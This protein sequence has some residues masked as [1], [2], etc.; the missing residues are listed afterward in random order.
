MPTGRF[1]E[2]QNLVP[3]GDLYEHAA[4]AVMRDSVAGVPGLTGLLAGRVRKEPIPIFDINGTL[5]F[6]DYA[7]GRGAQ[8]AGYVRTAASRIVGPPVVAIEIGPRH[9]DYAAAVRRLTPRVKKQFPGAALSEPMLVCYSYPKLGVMFHAKSPEKSTRVIFD[10]ADLSPIPENPRPE[11]E[12]AYAWSFYDALSDNDRRARSRRFAQADD[13]RTAL[14]SRVRAA[15]S[16]ARS[17]QA[18]VSKIDW[19][20]RSTVTKLLEYCSHYPYTHA[21][22]HHCF[23]LHAQQVNDYCAVATCQMILC[24][25][26]YYYA[27][28]AIAPA[29]SYS[30]GGGCPPDQSPGYESLSCNHIDATF[31]AAPTWQKARAQID[32]RRPFK[33]GVPGHARAC[34]GYSRTA[35]LLGGTTEEKLYIYDPWPW[36]ADFALGGTVVWEDWGTITHTNY[37]TTRI[38]CP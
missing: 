14:S 38:A 15:I 4:L 24:Y 5:L 28:T 31:D 32:L 2:E 11:R 34:A 21:R 20:F 3:A 8:V 25:Y 10:V 17:L 26:R 35:W 29:C 12:G 9:W 23:S 36:N 37:V 33:S 18:V 16:S 19:R 27:Q 13:A 6:Y 22:G 7:V 1:S 30:A